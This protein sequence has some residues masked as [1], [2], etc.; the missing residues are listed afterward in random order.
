MKN[1]SGIIKL[2]VGPLLA[3]LFLI[4]VDLDPQ[5]RL[6]TITAAIAIWM[7]FWWVTDFEGLNQRILRKE[8]LIVDQQLIL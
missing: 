1:K 8:Q 2:I 4:F 7:A 5:N 6:V 3:V